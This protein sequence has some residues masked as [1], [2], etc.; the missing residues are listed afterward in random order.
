MT[1]CALVS[2]VAN[3]R[4][5]GREHPRSPIACDVDNR[6]TDNQ[7]HSRLT[8]NRFRALLPSMSDM[9]AATHK[10]SGQV[11][12]VINRQRLIALTMER[13][14]NAFLPLYDD[15]ID[16]ILCRE[17]GKGGPADLRKIQL[18]SRWTIHKKYLG[19]DIWIAFPDGEDWYVAPHNELVALADQ[20]GFTASASWS[21][22]GTYHMATMSKKLSH[23]MKRWRI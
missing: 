4:Q 6:S 5:G 2:S 16:L 9:T 18:K 10:P 22:R 7:S 19:R 23:A 17:D 1:S 12:E 3:L 13:G 8:S 15:G 20:A 14:Y 21:E 11:I